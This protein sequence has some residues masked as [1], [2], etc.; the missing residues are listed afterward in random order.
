MAFLAESYPWIKAAH[1]LL[2]LASGGLFAGR[3]L[4][5]LMGSTVPLAPPLRRLSQGIDTALLI[6]ALLLLATLQINPFA[7]PWL[8]AKLALLVAYIVFGTLALRRAPTLAT[9]AMAYAAA[10][11]SFASM[12][13]VARSHDPLGF[14]APLLR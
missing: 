8:Q 7:M 11:A 3:G 1:V 10:L 2:A 5:V 12:F 13:A 6:A 14:L 9:K 4:G